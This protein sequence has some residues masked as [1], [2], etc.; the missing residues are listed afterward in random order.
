MVSL[1]LSPRLE[2]D[3]AILAYRNLHLPGSSDSYASA[4][5]VA[6]ITDAC[7]HPRLIFVFF[8]E[9]GF[10]HVGQAGLKLLTSENIQLNKKA[11]RRPGAV[12]HACNPST[13]GGRG[14]Q[15]TRSRDR[16][17]PGQHDGVSLLLPRLECNGVISAHHNLRLPVQ[18]Q[19]RSV[20]QAGVQWHNLSS[21]QHLPPGSSTYGRCLYSQLLKRLRQDN[22]LNLGGRDCSQ[23]RL[24]HCITAWATDQDSVSKQSKKKVYSSVQFRFCVFV[25]ETRS[26]FVTLTQ[27]G[28]QGCN[29]SSL[30]DLTLSPRLEC[31]GVIMTHCSLKLLGSTNPPT[32][33]SQ[34]AETTDAY[35]HTRLIFKFFCRDSVLLCGSDWSQIPGLK[36]SSHLSLPQH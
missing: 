32:S 12:A 17:H 6:G 18:T 30:E 14:G 36:Q 29:L 1:A 11:L 24:H 33:A 2:Y 8:V 28:V 16:D 21:L 26:G 35:H 13:L 7:H 3:G 22:H 27:A 5:Q 19:S 10:C 25:F 9:T 20:A 4:S 31:S 23:L 34:E 15:I